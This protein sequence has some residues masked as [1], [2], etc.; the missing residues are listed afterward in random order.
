MIVNVN[1]QPD[2]LGG[3]CGVSVKDFLNYINECGM[4]YPL[5]AIS[6][7]WKGYQDQV[8]TAK[9]SHALA[10]THLTSGLDYD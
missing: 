4:T 7:A 5:W 6:F 1:P 3:P 9:M 2:T 10:N 8:K